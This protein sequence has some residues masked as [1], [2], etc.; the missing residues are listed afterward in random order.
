MR[1][2]ICC[3][4]RQDKLCPIKRTT[5][6][7]YCVRIVVTGTHRPSPRLRLDS[8]TER[9]YLAWTLL[10][11]GHCCRCVAEIEDNVGEPGLDQPI[12]LPSSL[13][14]TKPLHVFF[15]NVLS[16]FMQMMQTDTDIEEWGASR[17]TYVVDSHAREDP[18][19]YFSNQYDIIYKCTEIIAIVGSSRQLTDTGQYNTYEVATYLHKRRGEIDR[20]YFPPYLRQIQ[21][22]YNTLLSDVAILESIIPNVSISKH[23]TI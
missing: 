21:N 17:R 14:S 9:I 20:V 7:L 4:A 6:Y 11:N 22:Q 3:E 16:C 2:I 13:Q 19:P 1:K 18:T 23:S 12:I 15:T 10:F 5:C 8:T